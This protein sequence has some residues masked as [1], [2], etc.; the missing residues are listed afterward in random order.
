RS[1]G[2]MDLVG[3]PIHLDLSNHPF[4]STQEIGYPR[5]SVGYLLFLT[6]IQNNIF[7]PGSTVPP[8]LMWAS[9]G[10]FDTISF[11]SCKLQKL[12]P[13]M[14]TGTASLGRMETLGDSLY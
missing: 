11:R 4:S 14:L 2:K 9:G 1:I 13:L 10:L 6:C 5:Y 8:G 3:F 12:D 7:W